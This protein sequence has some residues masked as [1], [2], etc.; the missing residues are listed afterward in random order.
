MSVDL[1]T[2]G[3]LALTQ[4][5]GGA[6]RGTCVQFTPAGEHTEYAQLTITDVVK[7]R[8]KLTA[9]LREYKKR[10]A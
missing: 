8:D 7:L 1:G 3:D 9:I 6:E 5:Y 10:N 2:V 4:F